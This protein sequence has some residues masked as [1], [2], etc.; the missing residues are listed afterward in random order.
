MSC[1]TRHTSNLELVESR[2]ARDASLL[3]VL[4]RTIHAYGARKLRAWILQPL[5]I[6]RTATTPANGRPAF[7]GVGLLGRFALIKSI[8]ESSAPP[9]D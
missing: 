6:S 7:A 3:S 2:G 4:D 8:R 1:S 9:D 5:P